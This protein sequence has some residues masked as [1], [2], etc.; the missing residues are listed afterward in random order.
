MCSAL[1]QDVARVTGISGTKD[2]F[3]MKSFSSEYEPDK[4]VGILILRALQHALY[5]AVD[6]LEGAQEGFING[7]PPLPVPQQGPRS[8]HALATGTASTVC[9]QADEA[10][11]CTALPQRLI[12]VSC[13]KHGSC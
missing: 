6:Y 12:F 10:F 3:P 8:A 2:V 1:N 9:M 4:G 5:A 11:A 13:A 7:R